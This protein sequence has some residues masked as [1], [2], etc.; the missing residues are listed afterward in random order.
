MKPIFHITH[1]ANLPDILR[2]GGLLCDAEAERRGLCAQSIAY[3]FVRTSEPDFS[4][5]YERPL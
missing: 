1:I 3:N 2:E 4:T 5:N